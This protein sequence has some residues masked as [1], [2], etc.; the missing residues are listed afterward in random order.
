MT[1]AILVSCI[2][3]VLVLGITAGKALAA[4]ATS[5]PTTQKS[6]G[7]G[8]GWLGGLN[9][10]EDQRSQIKAI[11]NE[12]KKDLADATTDDEKAKLKKAEHE[13]IMSVLTDE[14]KKTL[15]EHRKNV[16]GNPLI[17][18][19]KQLN[20]TDDQKAQIKQILQQ[21]K[22]DAQAATDKSAKKQ[23]MQ[24]AFKK[25]R[26]TVLTDEQRKKLQ[27][28][29]ANFKKDHPGHNGNGGAASQ[30]VTTT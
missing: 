2:V 10:T 30:P 16:G 9:L 19:V 20:L 8:G 26:D 24:D 27:E 1:K 28:L 3:A 25:I 13:K 4:D 11:R 22:Q 29:I 7:D 21:A 15:S 14:Q 17:G 12:T 18:L 23:I 6:H 5:Q